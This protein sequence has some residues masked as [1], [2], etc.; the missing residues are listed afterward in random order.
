MGKQ[1][2]FISHSPE[3]EIL[4]PECHYDWFLVIALFL[5]FTWPL[6]HYVLRRKRENKLSGISL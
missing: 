2:T 4:S 3:A 1:Q 6:S 5:A